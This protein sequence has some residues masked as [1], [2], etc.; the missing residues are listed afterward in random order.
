MGN[1][2]PAGA[3][4]TTIPEQKALKQPE[5]PYWSTDFGLDLG[6]DP[7]PPLAWLQTVC[8]VLDENKW[9]SVQTVVAALNDGTL[10][11]D[12]GLC[13]VK[14]VSKGTY[15]LLHRTDKLQEFADIA[16]TP[17]EQVDFGQQSSIGWKK[18]KRVVNAMMAANALQADLR[19]KQLVD[20]WDV[21][22]TMA[23][24]E[25]VGDFT[26]CSTESLP[27]VS[28][29]KWDKVRLVLKEAKRLSNGMDAA[30]DLLGTVRAKQVVELYDNE[31]WTKTTPMPEKSY[32]NLPDVVASTSVA[33]MEDLSVAIEPVA[34]TPETER[35]S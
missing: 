28:K 30:E 4:K 5:A 19:A 2:I 22:F 35:P 21:D 1:C 29:S 17:G 3:F 8:T 7:R 6:T 33:S 12:Q 11:V 9:D 20:E 31:D 15:W 13:V 25:S 23:N 16:Q 27:D 26:I 24:R 18:A 34:S 14:S 10:V 32:E